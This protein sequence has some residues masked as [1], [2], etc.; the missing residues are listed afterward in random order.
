MA[1]TDFISI[2]GIIGTLINAVVVWIILIIANKL[3]AHNLGAKRAFVLA[4]VALFITPIVASYIAIAVALPGLVAIYV[5][6]L[7]VWILLGEALL[8]GGTFKQKL[9][10]IVIAF[11]VYI[12]L[13]FI[14][15]Q[16]MIAS[17]IPAIA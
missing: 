14:G 6:P 10:V 17:M 5:I 15:V 16:G 7:I 13:T 1:I 4:F 9:E 8:K 12:I 2:G 11:V 3:I